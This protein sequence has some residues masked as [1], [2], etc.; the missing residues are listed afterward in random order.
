[1]LRRPPRSTRTDTLFPYTTLF[2]SLRQPQLAA[3]AAEHAHHPALLQA[4]V[5]AGADRGQQHQH[6]GGEREPEHPLDPGR[7]LVADRTH[8]LEHRVHVDHQ[9]TGRAS[10]ME[11]VGQTG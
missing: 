6:A 11:S 5:L 1:M 4:L 10:W 2:R 8:L 3:A 9:P 7:D